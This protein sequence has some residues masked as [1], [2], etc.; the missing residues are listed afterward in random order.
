MPFDIT[1]LGSGSA[2][3]VAHRH[4]AAQALRVGRHL[5]LIDC[6][7][8]AQ[9]QLRRARLPM[10]QLVAI[11]ITHLH[12]DHV[13]GLVPLLSSLNMTSRSQPLRIYAHAALEPVLQA[14]MEL[15]VG[16]LRF[17]YIFCPLDPRGG[18]RIYEDRQLTVDTV[19][20]H[21][22]VPCVGFLFREKPPQPNIRQGVLRG[23]ALGVEQIRMLKSGRDVE[24]PSGDVIR[25]SEA[26]YQRRLPVSYAYMSDTRYSES[27][28][29]AVSGVDLLYHEATFLEDE[30]PRARAT[31]HT[32]ARQAGQVA[33]LAGV[34]KLIIGHF[35]SR[36]MDLEPFL[37]E[38]QAM[39]PRT[40]L[41]REGETHRVAY[42]GGEHQ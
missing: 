24:L 36:Y 13:L 41:A 7:E 27:E 12:G 6:G 26:L 23:H 10:E 25:A 38:A 20:L 33:K 37:E 3:P 15:F 18:E 9:L 42:E 11:F 14:S 40:V 5:F 30:L 17:R 29:Q 16:E 8:G 1:I 2:M 19:L 22:R 28:A 35:S 32:T 4:P 31:G 34:G 21:H 39:F